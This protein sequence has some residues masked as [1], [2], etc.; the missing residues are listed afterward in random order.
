MLLQT[1]HLNACIIQKLH[2]YVTGCAKSDFC[3]CCHKHKASVMVTATVSQDF[4]LPI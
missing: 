2:N 1:E 4:L 3:C